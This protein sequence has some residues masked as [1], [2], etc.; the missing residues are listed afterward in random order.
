MNSQNISK[1]N[2][3]SSLRKDIGT[4]GEQLASDFLVRKGYEILVRNFYVR[5]G[6]IDIIA[7]LECDLIVVEVKTRTSRAYGFGEEAVDL[8]K[9]KRMNKAL[10]SY[11]ALFPIRY[12]RFDIVAVD[13][14]VPRHSVK[15]RHLK[16]IVFD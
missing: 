11:T 6:E 5:G 9:R 7:R 15:I 8:K 2:H 14:D 12:I 1:S 3:S 13:I 16:N 10:S 4:F